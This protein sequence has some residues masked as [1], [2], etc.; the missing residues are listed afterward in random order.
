LLTAPHVLALI[1]FGLLC[2]Q[3]RAVLLR[4]GLPSLSL[5]LLIG[6]AGALLA[7][8]PSGAPTLLTAMAL[9]CG[10]TAAACYRVPA[11]VCIVLGALIGAAIGFDSNPEASTPFAECAGMSGTAIAA[12]LLFLNIAG[13]AAFAALQWQHIG[14]RIA[15]SWMSAAAFLNIALLFRK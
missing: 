10:L 3:G 6:F 2:G 14:V 1:A 13:F 7:V 9:L 5:G 4:F 12:L 11:W 15:A 8:P